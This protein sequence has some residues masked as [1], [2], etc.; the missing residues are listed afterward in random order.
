MMEN[1]QD[2]DCGCCD[3]GCCDGED[4]VMTLE[5]DDGTQ[6]VCSVLT[7]F[8]VDGKQYI[9]LLPDGE[10]EEEG[11]IFFYRYSETP[12]GQPILGCIEGDEEYEAVIDRFDEILDEEE[13]DELVPADEADPE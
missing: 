5:L 13:Y 10:D 11:D 12:D 8:P 9:A 6:L 7:I 2:C 1:R 4:L 3:G